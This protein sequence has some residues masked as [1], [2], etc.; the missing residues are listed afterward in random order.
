MQFVCHGRVMHPRLDKT[1]LFCEINFTDVAIMISF[2]V[3]EKDCSI[4]I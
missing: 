1:R 2:S 4:K 3:K